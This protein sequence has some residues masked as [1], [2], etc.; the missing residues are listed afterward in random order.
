MNSDVLSYPT[1]HAYCTA[2]RTMGCQESKANRIWPHRR[3]DRTVTPEK[4][5]T[6][7]TRS[8]ESSCPIDQRQAFKIKQSW[9]GI[10]RN[11]EITGIEMF[12]RCISVSLAMGRGRPN[13]PTPASGDAHRYFWHELL[14]VEMHQ[15]FINKSVVICVVFGLVS[16]AQSLQKHCAPH[17]VSSSAMGSEK[18]EVFLPV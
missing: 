16:S 15:N 17:R 18:F 4:V 1:F 5:V 8:D 9:K 11:M 2:R 13:M 12:M 10:R 14:P 7:G 6:R 3:F